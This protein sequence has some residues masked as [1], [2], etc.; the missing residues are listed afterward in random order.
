MVIEALFLGVIRKHVKG[1]NRL[2]G[3]AWLLNKVYNYETFQL[4][5]TIHKTIHKTIHSEYPIHF[6]TLCL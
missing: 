2:P 6:R 3:S 4:F 1:N 5:T